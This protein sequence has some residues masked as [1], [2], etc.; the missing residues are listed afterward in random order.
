MNIRKYIIRRGSR[1]LFTILGI[2]FSSALL[3]SVGILFSSFREYLIKSVEK[4]IGNYHVIV[5][6]EVKYDDSMESF[7]YKDGR[8]YITYKNINK[9]YKNTD[10]ICGDKKCESI[11]YNDSLLSLYGLSKNENILFIFKKMIIFIVF[12]FGVILFFILY[13]SF[14][15]SLN[16]RRRDI[17][18]FKL[19]GYNNINL[20]KLFIK[21]SMIL[22]FIGILL[23]FII[24]LILNY[25]IM[26]FLNNHLFEIFGGNLRVKIYF[27]FVVIP[28]FLIIFIVFLSSLIPLKNIRKYKIME[29]FRINS[30]CENIK[31]YPFKN[32][33]LWFSL[34]NYKRNRDKYKSLIVSIFISCLVMS[35][36]SLV[37]KYTLKC[38]GDFVTI[39]SYD[40][41]VTVSEDY[42]LNKLASDLR[43]SKKVIYNS[44][45]YKA[46]IPSENYLSDYKEEE[47]VLVTNL[48]GN[49]VI[50]K[51]SKVVNDDK[52]KKL[53]FKRFKD[54]K[55]INLKGDSEIKIDSLKLTDK[56]PF[57]FEQEDSVV[58][59]LDE[60]KFD[61]V[62]PSFDSN[63][64]MKTDYNGMDDY[65]D[66]I[67]KNREVNM[68]FYNVKKARQIMENLVYA[69]KIVIYGVCFL[70]ILT[71]LFSSF[72]ITSAVI[73]FRKHELS[74]LKSIGFENRKMIF[75]LFLES[76]L[77][78][79][80]GWFYC[81]P[82]VFI[83]N[84]Y[85]FL[86]I[87]E[88]FDFKRMILGIDV[89]VFGFFIS[90]LCVFLPMYF[91]Y[92]K[93]GNSL[94]SDIKER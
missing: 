70:I 17:C 85:I 51:V 84:K 16:N 78:S 62:C 38:L 42:N 60:D 93:M 22:G 28:A 54:L 89:I 73:Y 10:R 49:E 15:V 44:C 81:L 41:K 55:E 33:A 12:S 7:D 79:I 65:L 77:V 72:N 46:S 64:I 4:E 13:N 23:G 52:F 30:K 32:V 36:F 34:I 75:S 57:G 68:V 21:E 45:A 11:T 18:L 26:H 71:V 67:I 47:D 63:L 74:S 19:I 31:V 69:I 80:K 92:K 86:S 91:S 59:N 48:G 40:L 82:F 9:V 50:N 83:V 6:G 20:Y 61:D 24:S 58:V 53:D 43:A 3:I 14:K 2:S 27:S 88:V 25:F 5:A 90:F 29:L 37:L 8:Y 35:I 76:L 66:D 56:A 94:I 87:R 1:S 39:P